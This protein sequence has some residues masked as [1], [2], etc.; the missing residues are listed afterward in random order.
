MHA[1]E[2]L[3]L[4]F[5]SAFSPLLIAF[6]LDEEMPTERRSPNAGTAEHGVIEMFH[7]DGREYRTLHTLEISSPRSPVS[8]VG[9]AQTPWGADYIS[10]LHVSP[11]ANPRSSAIGTGTK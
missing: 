7:M 6:T 9:K 3:F 5:V 11:T 4:S 2:R 8:Q 10:K 1:D